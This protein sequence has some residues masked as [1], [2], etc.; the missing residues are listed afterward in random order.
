MKKTNFSGPAFEGSFALPAARLV[1]LYSFTLI[2]LLVVIAMIAILA[3]ML[4]PAL[5][6]ARNTA[7][8][9]NC[10]SNL[11]QLALQFTTYANDNQ[12]WMIAATIPGPWQSY[13][14][15]QMGMISPADKNSAF[16]A[17]IHDGKVSRTKL[18]FFACP[19]EA[20]Q[21]GRYRTPEYHYGH[22]GINHLLTGSTTENHGYPNDLSA[23]VYIRTRKITEISKP[24]ITITMADYG[25]LGLPYEPN[26]HAESS[27]LEYSLATRHGNRS[28]RSK[29]EGEV[30]FYPTGT[31]LNVAF[32]DGRASAMQREYW[33]KDNSTYTIVPFVRGYR[34]RNGQM[35]L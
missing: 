18:N 11:K 5:Q 28:G 12:D 1:K 13:F 16:G 14:A 26:W 8:Q 15:A 9:S 24:S 20:I 21:I 10:L 33:K 23:N 4:L 30:V 27:K 25:R 34:N 2:E 22:Y 19:A 35:T 17:L 31:V 6:S 29:I 3:A 7:K 32:A